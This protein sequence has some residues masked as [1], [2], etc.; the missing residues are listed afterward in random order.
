MAGE[1]FEIKL[2]PF[3]Q[4]FVASLGE[5]LYRMT[6]RWNDSLEGCWVLDISSQ[7]DEPI[8]HGIAVVGGVDLL[9]PYQY[10]NIGGGGH[11]YVSTDGDLLTPPT[12]ENLGINA[13]L[14]WQPYK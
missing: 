3:D 6:I 12:Q 7:E 14:L 13:H 1:V 10:L 11:L 5:H 2:S 8:V 9:S 4:H